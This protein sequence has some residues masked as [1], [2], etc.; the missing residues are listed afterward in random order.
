MWGE[1]EPMTTPTVRKLLQDG[2]PTQNAIDL[3]ILA[4]RVE[5]VLALH[6]EGDGPDV[7]AGGRTVCQHCRHS[8]PCSTVRLLNVERP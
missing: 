3:E 5:A 1:G 6:I 7:E 4:A 8:W 2:G